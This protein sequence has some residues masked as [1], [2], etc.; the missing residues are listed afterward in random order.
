MTAL[1]SCR[2][3]A[4]ALC[5]ALAAALSGCAATTSGMQAAESGPELSVFGRISVRKV[6]K[7]LLLGSYEW[8][9]G[10]GFAGWTE[11][12]VVRSTEGMRVFDVSSDDTGTV[13]RFLDSARRVESLRW[14]VRDQLGVDVAPAVLAGWLENHHLGSE[15]PDKA[16]HEGV[17]VDVIDRHGDGRPAKIRLVQGE[18]IVLMTVRREYA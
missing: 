5:L 10:P 14:L 4:A 13:V 11:S 9:R 3:L 18:T 1:R 6:A 2:P 16:E 17:R 8:N 15:L 12:F 7:P